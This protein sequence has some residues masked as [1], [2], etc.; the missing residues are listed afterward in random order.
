MALELVSCVPRRW[1]VIASTRRSFVVPDGLG[2][3]G[4]CHKRMGGEDGMVDDVEED[5]LA[6]IITQLSA[7]N[8]RCVDNLLGVR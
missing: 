6:L 1:R 3:P 4:G 2:A 8:L 5:G 7:N